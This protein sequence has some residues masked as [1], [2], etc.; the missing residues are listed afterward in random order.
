ME[1]ANNQFK[2]SSE[3]ILT[4]LQICYIQ[5]SSWRFSFR[6][7]TQECLL[8]V[9][10]DIF[11]AHGRCISWDKC[12]VSL[13]EKAFLKHWNAHTE[14]SSFIQAGKDRGIFSTLQE[15]GK[16]RENY[17]CMIS[18]P[19]K[20]AG[21]K[22]TGLLSPN[23]SYRRN[24]PQLG[25][26]LNVPDYK[27]H[28]PRKKARRRRSNGMFVIPEFLIKRFSFCGCRLR[29][30]A[31]KNEGRRKK[32]ESKGSGVGGEAKIIGKIKSFF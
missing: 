10:K 9:F 24:F 26:F 11:E 29:L 17:P 7:R 31:W 16:L 14:H 27:A 23:K 22:K 28:P 20:E 15:G 21:G 5:T 2:R 13:E 19:L 12:T 8:W 30:H 25:G 4:S 32:D 18:R 1:N 6:R 3:Y